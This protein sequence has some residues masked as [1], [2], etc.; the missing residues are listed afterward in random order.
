MVNK[1]D[2]RL[3]NSWRSQRHTRRYHMVSK[4][5]RAKIWHQ[6]PSLKPTYVISYTDYWQC[7][8][9]QI[10]GLCSYDHEAIAEVLYA[11]K[12]CKWAHIHC[13]KSVKR[14][15]N[16][17]WYFQPW[18][19]CLF[20]F[21]N[22]IWFHLQ[23]IAI[24]LSSPCGAPLHIN[25]NVK[26]ARALAGSTF[27][28]YSRFRSGLKTKQDPDYSLNFFLMTQCSMQLCLRLVSNQTRRFI[29]RS[30]EA[31]YR[32]CSYIEE[33]AVYVINIH[34]KTVQWESRKKACS[35]IIGYHCVTV[36]K[37]KRRKGSI[38]YIR[39]SIQFTVGF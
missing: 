16:T 9:A 15:Y 13:Q 22:G 1:T 39:H 4:V 28:M 26:K 35:I 32:E 12:P 18:K 27:G 10:H 30:G 11:L 3:I 5:Q 6:L 33:N 36:G 21:L 38:R 37:G 29:Y 20:T 7:I 19:L 31:L 17:A 23:V 2:R 14:F 34:D 24:Y 8:C 25:Q